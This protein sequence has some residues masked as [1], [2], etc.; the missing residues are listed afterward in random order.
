[1]AILWDKMILTER[2]NYDTRHKTAHHRPAAPAYRVPAGTAPEASGHG[3]QSSEAKITERGLRPPAPAAS[4]Q[5]R[6]R[7]QAASEQAHKHS[8][9]KPQAPGSRCLDKVSGIAHRGSVQGCKY[10]LDA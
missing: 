1:M 3:T 6:A 4:V 2:I 7:I 5:A 9:H 10:S 8:S